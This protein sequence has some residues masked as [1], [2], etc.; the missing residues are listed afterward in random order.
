MSLRGTF[1]QVR[2]GLKERVGYKIAEGLGA[3]HLDHGERQT[4]TPRMRSNMPYEPDNGSL[5]RS[6]GNKP[7]KEAPG[8]RTSRGR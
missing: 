5:T 8:T 2:P 7:L 1:K 6:S 4:E 3:L